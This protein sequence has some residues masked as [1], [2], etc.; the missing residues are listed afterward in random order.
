[1][2]LSSREDLYDYCSWR[3][4]VNVSHYKC[5]KIIRNYKDIRRSKK[6]NLSFVCMRVYKK[7]LTKLI[8]ISSD[9]SWTSSKSMINSLNYIL[10]A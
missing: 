8:I 9:Q 2:L 7:D 5:Y 4:R 1:M 6:T 3:V 10:S